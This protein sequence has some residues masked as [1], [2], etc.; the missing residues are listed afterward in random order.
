MKKYLW[1]ALAL[2][3]VVFLFS[4]NKQ[5]PVVLDY[6]ESGKEKLFDPQGLPGDGYVGSPP[7]DYKHKDY[8]PSFGK[9]TQEAAKQEEKKEEGKEGEKEEK[10]PDKDQPEEKK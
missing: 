6:K 2:V 5:K 3:A 9:D 7:E 8:K 1:I 10:K 4:C